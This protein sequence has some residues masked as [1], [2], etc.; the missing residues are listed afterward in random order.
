[1]VCAALPASCSV[2]YRANP[3]PGPLR[4]FL[5]R[6]AET[7][8]TE[9]KAKLRARAAAH[10][11]AQR[12][13]QHRGV[14]GADRADDVVLQDGGNVVFTGIGGQ[15]QDVQPAH[16]V[17]DAHR[18]LQPRD[19]NRADPRLLQEFRDFHVAQSQSIRLEHRDQRRTA[20]LLL[21]D[22]QVGEDSFGLYHQLH[23]HDHPLSV[24]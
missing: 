20:G 8:H 7:A 1:M 17:R 6:I 16:R 18:L 4:R 22:A 19:R 24:Y 12:A 3:G 2:P 21:Q 13:E 23:V 11:A 14:V 15:Q 5:R 10:T 9:I